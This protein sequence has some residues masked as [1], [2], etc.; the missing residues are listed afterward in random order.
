MVEHIPLHTPADPCT[1][2][3]HILRLDDVLPVEDLVAGGL[4]RGVEQAAAD[5]GQDAQLHIVVLQV[6]RPVRAIHPLRGGI[7][8]HGVGIHPAPGPLIGEIPLEEG[9][10]F[11]SCYAV[12]GEVDGALPHFHRAVLGRCAEG[13]HHQGGYE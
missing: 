10:L 8:V 4:V 11:G 2:H 7:V 3:T 5:V 12:G 9:G 13:K 1:E 6:E